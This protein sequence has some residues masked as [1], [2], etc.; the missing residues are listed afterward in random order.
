[1]GLVGFVVAVVFDVVWYSISWDLHGGGT[2]AS[3]LSF[4]CLF[5]CLFIL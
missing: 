3:S 5:I 2:L 1:M 4:V